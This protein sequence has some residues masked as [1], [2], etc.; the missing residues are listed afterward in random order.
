[1]KYLYLLLLLPLLATSACT[2]VRTGPDPDY[3]SPDSV[4]GYAPIYDSAGTG[5]TISA[6]GPRSIVDAGKIYVKGTTLYQVENGSGIHVISIADVAH[7]Q[8]QKFI[9]IL[10][11]AEL[12]IKDNYLYANNINDL[13]VV[14]IADINNP[15]L[16]GRVENAFH[17]T[18]A[19]RGGGWYQCVDGSK[20]ALIGWKMK[21]LY[22][23]HCQF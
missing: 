3:Y 16:K 18:S 12:A 1:M 6:T 15:K 8:K 5:K 7:P 22:H 13:V 11:C 2:S 4:M 10:G 9:Q 14:D 20:G 19:P 17:I 21:T 23:P